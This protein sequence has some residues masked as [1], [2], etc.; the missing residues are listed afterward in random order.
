MSLDEHWEAQAE[1]WL[2]WARTPGHDIYWGFSGPR[3]FEILPPP[4]RL[5]VELGC[6]EGR[7]CRDLQRL[8][9]RTLGVELSATLF[10]AAREADPAGEY[11][12]ADAAALPLE[13][14]VANLVVAF[15]SL[16]DMEDMTGAI[17]EAARILEPGGRFCI[18]VPHPFLN[19]GE[20]VD[21][22]DPGS[23][24]VIRG[25]YFAYAQREFHYERGG[26]EMT[27]QSFELPLSALT[28]PLEEAGFRLELFREPPI[29]DDLVAEHAHRARW[30][31]LPMFLYLRAVKS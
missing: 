9:H 19:G 28:R 7:V 5:T 23:V 26:L 17:R 20:W 30:Q 13:N 27:F 6:G 10:R 11:L 29:D 25:S 31:R 24:F 14:G 3:L 1:N 15:N 2:G 21:A 8:G 22:N 12:H 18:C 16:I 4:G